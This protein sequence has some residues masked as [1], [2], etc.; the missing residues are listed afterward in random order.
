LV[1]YFLDYIVPYYT[2]YVKYSLNPANKAL[3]ASHAGEE[4]LR[5]VLYYR[6]HRI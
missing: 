6:V 2:Q 5:L 1:I 4:F 3:Q